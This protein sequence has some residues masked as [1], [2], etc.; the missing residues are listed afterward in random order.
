MGNSS[1]PIEVDS[2]GG[3]SKHVF[4]DRLTCQ[5]CDWKD[6]GPHRISSWRYKNKQI[7]GFVVVVILR[8]TVGQN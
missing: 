8:L 1:E 3:I 6:L 7:L 5:Y 4:L 2:M